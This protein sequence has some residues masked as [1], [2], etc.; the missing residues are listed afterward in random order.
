MK[1]NLNDIDGMVR[2]LLPW[3]VLDCIS[4]SRG[5]GTNESAVI[6]ISVGILNKEHFRSVG[7]GVSGFHS[8]VP[9]YSLHIFTYLRTPVASKILGSHLFGRIEIGKSNAKKAE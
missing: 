2:T 7:G 3:Y 6:G 1:L 4:E 9:V 5:D 8:D